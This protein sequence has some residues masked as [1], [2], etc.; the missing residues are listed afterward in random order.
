MVPEK[1][2]AHL[3]AHRGG[4][5]YWQLLLVRDHVCSLVGDPSGLITIALARPKTTALVTALLARLNAAPAHYG[6]GVPYNRLGL[7]VDVRYETSK[8]HTLPFYFLTQ[9]MG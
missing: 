1:A 4:G 2:A 7:E 3:P 9:L 5:T 6:Y 8:A